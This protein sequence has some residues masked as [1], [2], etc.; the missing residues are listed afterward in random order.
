MQTHGSK[1]KYDL[2]KNYGLRPS[3]STESCRGS[4]PAL[5][6]F[7]LNAY[8][9]ELGDDVGWV[10]FIRGL[11]KS[12]AWSHKIPYFPP[13]T[14]SV[15]EMTEV[16]FPHVTSAF[17]RFDEKV[18]NLGDQIRTFF[19]TNLDEKANVTFVSKGRFVQLVQIKNMRGK[20]TEKP[21]WWEKLDIEVAYRTE[22]KLDVNWAYI[23]FIHVEG[24]YATGAE[25]AREPSDAAYKIIADKDL[26]RY[27]KVTIDKLK[28]FLEG[29]HEG[30]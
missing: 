23:Y 19:R 29:A 22:D 24:Q 30:H 11:P 7:V 25:G 13:T 6:G 14:A 10:L 8:S 27:A 3:L 21:T 20:I 16:R 5:D 9:T 1:A 26:Q 12:T 18:G 17:S 2:E 15:D 28:L 4:Q